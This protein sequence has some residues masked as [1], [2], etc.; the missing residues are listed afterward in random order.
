MSGRL[1]IGHARTYTIPD[2]VARFKRAQGYAV[3]FPMAWHVTGTPIIGISKRIEKK[4]EFA[5]EVYNKVHG[6]PK[7]I[8]MTFTDPFKLV[9]YF[10]K[11]SKQDIG[12]LGC[13]IDWRRVFTT[14]DLAYQRFIQWQYNKLHQQGLVIKGTFR[15]KWC[16]SC[17]NPVGEHDL[18]TGETADI[19]DYVLIKF[20]FNSEFLPAATLRPETVLGVTNMW[21][22]P[23]ASYSRV[24]VNGET[25]I[26]SE[27]SVKKLKYLD[28]NIQVV[29]T[30][31]GIE[32]IGK[33][34]YNP[35]TNDPIIVLPTSFVNPEEAS[36][37]VMSVP[38]HA[39]YDYIALKELQ[40]NPA[41]LRNYNIDAGKVKQIKMIPL[42]E[43]PGFGEFPAAEI[44]ERMGITRQ[45]DPKLED[46]TVEIY[47]FEYSKGTMRKSI[48]KYGGMH[49]S[50]ARET[51]EQDM[52]NAGS[53]DYMYDF[54]E[55]PVTCRCGTECVIKTVQDQWF[56]KY[57]DENWKKKAT[58]C[59]SHMKIYPQ[60][61]L[62]EFLNTI[63]WLK[64]RA[65]SRQ[66]GL[67][68]TLPWDPRWLIES[69]S[70]STIYMAFYIISK[71]IN[72][73]LI[74]PEHLT[75]EIFDFIFLGK[76]DSKSLSKKVSLKEEVLQKLKNE[77]YYW[78]PLDVRFSAKDLIPNHLTFFVFH[79]A[80][81]FPPELCPRAISVNGYVSVEG[82]K[83]SKSKGLQ[84][85]LGNASTKYGA[86]L[87]RFYLISVA[88]LIQDADWREQNVQAT[89]K[90]LERFWNLANEIIALRG[91]EAAGEFKTID[92][93]LLNQIQ[94][95]I[96]ET[97]EAF[98]NFELRRALHSAFFLFMQDV[99]WYIRRSEPEMSDVKR[100]ATVASLLHKALNV[101][102]RLLAP[103]IPHICEELWEKIEKPFVSKAPWPAIERQLVDENAEL[104]ENLIEKTLADVEEIIKVTNIKPTKVYF[105]TVPTWKLKVFREIIKSALTEKSNISKIMKTAMEDLEIK[106]HGAEVAKFVQQK[107]TEVGSLSKS[108]IE[109]L[110]K[111]TLSEHNILAEASQFFKQALGANLVQVYSADDPNRYDPQNK[112]KFA[113]PF[114]P[115]IYIE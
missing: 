65:C 2:V 35:V 70:D 112:A 23:H 69:L 7:D 44:V 106:K 80:A 29:Q 10:S 1:H 111:F 87:T 30:F 66:V 62:P 89:E 11:V 109:K 78:Y 5:I 32:L 90:Q 17:K 41:E 104:A 115:A 96:T 50:V 102:L 74:K 101:W 19:K 63:N 52:V 76:G 73:G 43:N 98:E 39:P 16:P 24:K 20:K 108:E 94:K 9:D 51:I 92:R 28:K 71:Y 4:D 59:F 103:F 40:Q 31:K 42:I 91:E 107:A 85:N 105:Y 47:T 81:I 56:L 97:T 54:T 113:V 83:M 93:W 36:G 86:D 49:V 72:L 8:L 34:C 79:H 100:K 61:I 14:T 33:F 25:W 6:V 67:G 64:Q 88:E 27:A 77:F 57:A 58:D 22:N 75:E 38:S 21:I 82:Q 84:V 15:V 99:R 95:R 13:S 48:K 68:T 55:K 18:L 46:A 110:E 3:L 45:T 37:V 12:S 114:R 53:A 60:E 26:V